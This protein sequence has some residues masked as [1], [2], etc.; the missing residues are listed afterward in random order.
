M[1]YLIVLFGLVAASPSWAAFH[2][3]N[4]LLNSCEQARSDPYCIGY[5]AGLV[6]GLK[7]DV[8]LPAGATSRQVLD[9]L[10][11]YLKATPEE[12]L[13]DNGHSLR[14]ALLKKPLC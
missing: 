7:K 9:I 11:D 14:K 10:I 2:N 3:G 12:R 1:R 13:F 5:A 4:T 8:C 6:D